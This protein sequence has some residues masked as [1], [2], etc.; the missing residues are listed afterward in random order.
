VETSV[1][2]AGYG[3]DLDQVT[4]GLLEAVNNRLLVRPRALL[5][6]GVKPMLD[7]FRYSGGNDE[8]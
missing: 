1:V 7:E 5:A 8:Q 2:P 6:L 4:V 3:H